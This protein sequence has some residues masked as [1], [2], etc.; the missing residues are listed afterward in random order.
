[1]EA[2]FLAAIREMQ[3]EVDAEMEK[4]EKSEK[5]QKENKDEKGIKCLI[6]L[7]R[8]ILWK[9]KISQCEKILMLH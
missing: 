8:A 2:L 3:L 9:K 4:L 5:L 6:S 1:M 7:C